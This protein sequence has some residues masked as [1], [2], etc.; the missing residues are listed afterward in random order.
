MLAELWSLSLLRERWAPC[1]RYVSTLLTFGKAFVLCR[2]LTVLTLRRGDGPMTGRPLWMLNFMNSLY[3]AHFFDHVFLF[4]VPAGW[5][6]LQERE[7][8][9]D[10][11]ESSLDSKLGG[12]RQVVNIY[13]SL[14]CTIFPVKSVG[15]RHP[16]IEICTRSFFLS[17]HDVFLSLKACLA[18]T[19]LPRFRGAMACEER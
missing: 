12:K 17:S 1:P 15:L 18:H 11:E 3:L 13:C 5:S 14:Q 4:P 8:L 19:L 9:S 7:L 10:L 16:V 2:Q 6:D